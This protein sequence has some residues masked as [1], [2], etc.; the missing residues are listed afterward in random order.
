MNRN[1][2]RSLL[3]LVLIAMALFSGCTCRTSVKPAATTAPTQRPSSSPA[4]TADTT[5]IPALT[6]SPEASAPVSPSA[7]AMA[8]NSADSGNP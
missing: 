5:V 3:G 2:I 8:T 6:E 4:A 7:D 1:R